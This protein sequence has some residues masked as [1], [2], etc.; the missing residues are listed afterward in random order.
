MSGG[1]GPDG[2]AIDEQGNLAVCHPGLGA[3]WLFSSRGEPV[4]RI[5]SPEGLMTTNCAYGGPGGKRLY[6]TESKSGTILC[7]DL[8]VAGFP[9][10]SHA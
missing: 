5:N 4:Y 9:L 7:A 1:V 2:M 10:Y 3:V 8:P 6:I